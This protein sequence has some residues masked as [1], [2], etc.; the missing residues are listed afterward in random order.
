[1]RHDA[2]CW[3]CPIDARWRLRRRA[4]FNGG[5]F[6]IVYVRWL[7]IIN[8]LVSS[9]LLSLSWICYFVCSIWS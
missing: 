9:L 6:L 1:M 5:D 8:L 3:E 7:C 4:M 2:G